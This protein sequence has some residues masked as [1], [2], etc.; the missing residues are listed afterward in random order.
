MFS[1]LFA[2]FGSWNLRFEWY[3]QYSRAASIYFACYLQHLGAGTFI[4]HGIC[5]IS[6]FQVCFLQGICAM[7]KLQACILYDMHDFGSANWHFGWR[8]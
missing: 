3:L 1:L 2:A 6:Q 8:L 5:S 7:L 4:S